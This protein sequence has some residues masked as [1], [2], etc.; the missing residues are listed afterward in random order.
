MANLD[1]GETIGNWHR[2]RKR[3]KLVTHGLACPKP[4]DKLFFQQNLCYH[5]ADE[6]IRLQ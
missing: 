6:R 2:L 5:T 1:I 4:K 3:M